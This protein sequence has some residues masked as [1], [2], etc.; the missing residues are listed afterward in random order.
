MADTVELSI[1]SLGVTFDTWKSYRFASDFLTPT[2]AFS[3]DLG[4]D[5]TGDALLA[6]LVPGLRVVLRIND[7]VQATG[8]IDTV[9]INTSRSGGTCVSIEGRDSMGPVVDG[10]ADPQTRYNERQTLNDVLRSVFGQFGFTKFLESNNVNR[11][12]ITGRTRGAPTTPKKGN[13]KASYLKHMLKPYP[14]E[15]A[16]AFASRLSQRSGFWIWPSSDGETIIVGV[17]N[18]DQSPIAKIARYRDALGIENTVL[19]GTVIRSTSEQ[20]SIIVA[21]GTGGGDANYHGAL[22]IVAANNAITGAPTADIFARHKEAK[23]LDM[24]YPHT[25]FRVPL[26]R[27]MFLHDEESHTLVELENYVRR[28]MTLR[29]RKMLTARYTVEGH[30]QNG[31]IWAVDTVVDVHDDVSGLRENMYVLGRTFSKDRSGGTKTTLDLI[32]LHTLVF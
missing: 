22:K 2:D 25:P 7:H 23:I 19:D 24:P 8:Y 18:F 17:P 27:P 20:P 31:A 5:Q 13:I 14:G 28:E 30:S 9:T 21:T 4:D 6:Q 1:P 15:G 16:F 26:A 3:F 12:V 11:N 32:R 29:H 10:N